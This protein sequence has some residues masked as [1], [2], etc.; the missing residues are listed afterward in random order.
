MGRLV[1]WGL[2]ASVL[3]GCGQQPVAEA[4]DAGGQAGGAVGGGLAG[5]A[6]GGLGGG[7]APSC[8][9]GP[10]GEDELLRLLFVVDRG[11]LMCAADPPG[12]SDQPTVCET[13]APPAGVTLPARTRALLA[14]LTE[15]QGRPNV[16]VAVLRFGRSASRAPFFQPDSTFLRSP[17]SALQ[18]ELDGHSNLQ[19]ALVAARAA[20]GENALRL[21]ADDRARARYVVVLVSA[22]VPTPRCSSVDVGTQVPTTPTG[23][24]PDTEG[25]E[26]WCNDAPSDV[27][28]ERGRFIPGG[29][30]NQPWQLDDAVDDLVALPAALG[31]RDVRVDAWHLL[32]EATVQRC[33][34]A[35]QGLFGLRGAAPGPVGNALMRHLS[36][37]GRGA[38][39]DDG[40][41]T[42][43]FAGLPLF[44]RVCPP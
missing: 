44:E 33:G 22:G 39:T 21:S 34:A 15:A 40:L 4:P 41:S 43:S 10:V 1:T 20:I 30:L 29:D 13:L 36:Q 16:E 8:M 27:F 24:W 38:F 19:G 42:A 3:V 37:R 14:L 26:A 17:I 28:D 9:A 25:F 11:T 31:V 6:G 35:C 12:V 5:A 32:D 2:W 23:R 7:G 18:A